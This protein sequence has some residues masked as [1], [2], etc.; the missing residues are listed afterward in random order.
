MRITVRLTIVTLII[1]LGVT[2]CFLGTPNAQE[3]DFAFEVISVSSAWVTRKDNSVKSS[4]KVG[5]ALY[6]G[7]KIDVG[8][9]HNLQLSMNEDRT[10]VLHVKGPTSMIVA[11]TKN[12]SIELKNGQIFS[13]L[14]DLEAGRDF[15]IKTPLAIASVRG[16]H[17]QVRHN[18][19]S[20]IFT[21]EGTVRVDG[22]D[23]KGY[24]TGTPVM[25]TANLRTIITPGN[26]SPLKPMP[27]ADKEIAKI[28]IVR[29]L[30]EQTRQTLDDTHVASRFGQVTQ[31][32][33]QLVPGQSRP[34]FEDDLEKRRGKLVY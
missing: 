17:Y 31:K 8:Y 5:D 26:T 10:N 2:F 13:L 7:D 19:F 18:D 21:Y 6:R 33:T 12:V 3:D 22:R 34:E 1:T 20:Q 9:N 11:R 28:N 32:S 4:L 15:K 29:N 24:A 23:A 25:V 16:T 27:I 14:D 30:L